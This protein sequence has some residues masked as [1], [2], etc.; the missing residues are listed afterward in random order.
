MNKKFKILSVI[1]SIII[2]I[3]FV[4]VGVILK[5]NQSI[6][7]VNNNISISANYTEVDTTKKQVETTIKI[8]N[9]GDI[10]IHSPIF[11]SV[12]NSENNTYDF[13]NIFKYVKDIY[14][15][16]DYMVA[17]LEQP[18]AGEEFGYSGFPLFNA[19]DSIVDALKNNGVDMLLT[20]NNHSYDRGNQGFYNTISSLKEKNIDFIGIRDKDDKPYLVKDIKGIKVGF[21]N[22]TYETQ[23]LSNTKYINGI[24]MN[25][26]T[27]PLINSFDYNNLDAFYKDISEKIS[28]M[29]NDGAE[30]IITYLHWGTEYSIS[31]ND[32]QKR[33][34][35]KLCDLGVDAIIGGHTHCLEPIDMISSTI[36]GKQ[37]PI[38]YS[39]GNQLSNQRKE[40]LSKFSYDSPYCEDGVIYSI[41]ITK[42]TT[43]EVVISDVNY[44]ATWCNLF[45]SDYYILPLDNEENY[46]NNFANFNRTYEMEKSLE[47]SKG[48]FDNGLNKIK[49]N[50][51]QIDLRKDK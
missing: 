45:G 28:L 8:G 33:I 15:D 6:P 20:A 18:I 13:N 50:Y 37:T 27:A 30:V 49:T 17:N 24:P 44:T 7:S 21:I 41:E 16:F 31:A 42:K 35:Q 1:L 3:S 46:K 19:P 39:T 10:L 34:A 14:S 36:S 4:V 2:I 48:L 12:Y 22:Y 32:Y 51:K 25:S 38:I 47:R 9:T 23:K 26:E 11:R 5:T 40:T 43:G 29:Y